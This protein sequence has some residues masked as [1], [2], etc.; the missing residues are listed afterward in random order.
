MGTPA[1]FRAGRPA[2]ILITIAVLAV[3]YWLGLVPSDSPDRS[4]SDRGK[5]HATAETIPRPSEAIPDHGGVS[6]H[7]SPAS[8][9]ASQR[10][11][12]ANAVA[13]VDSGDLLY[14]LLRE[15]SGRQYLSPAGL[16]YGP[17][18]AEGHRLDHLQRHTE[19]DPGRAGSH[20]VFDGGMA[21]ALTTIDLAYERAKTGQRTT[22]EVDRRSNHSYG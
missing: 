18:S 10:E 17:G 22:T 21:G 5:P 7:N 3:A 11:V 20:G 13:P 15:I 2:S 8:E 12:P 9:D 16:I 1:T 4:I 19:D 14:G 6:A